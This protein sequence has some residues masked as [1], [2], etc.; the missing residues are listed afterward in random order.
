[1]N[2]TFD[3]A[4]NRSGIASFAPLIRP[5]TLAR[6]PHPAIGTDRLHASV[7][8]RSLPRVRVGRQLA[9]PAGTPVA[10]VANDSPANEEG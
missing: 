9:V 2:A 8:S 3:I 6:L 4:S 7:T 1:M 5:I 10:S